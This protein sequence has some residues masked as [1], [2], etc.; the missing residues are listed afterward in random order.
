MN[1]KAVVHVRSNVRLPFLAVFVGTLMLT[2]RSYA[3]AFVSLQE[4]I[5]IPNGPDS[6]KVLWPNSPFAGLKLLQNT[7]CASGTWI[8]NTNPITTANGTNSVTI[9]PAVGNMFYRLSTP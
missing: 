2:V 7:N 5:I 9:T 6:V 1:K 3:P 8:M 4:P